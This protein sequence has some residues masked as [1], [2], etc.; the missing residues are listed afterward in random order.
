VK[1]SHIVELGPERWVAEQ[2]QARRGPS[3]AV[4]GLDDE[5]LGNVALR[6]PGRASPATTCRAIRA[7]DHPVGELSYWV[8]PHA[9]RRGVATA[10][11]IAMLDMA[12]GIEEVRSVVLDIEIDNVASIRVAER[13]GATR[14]EPTRVEYDRRGVPRE[15]AVFIV[16]V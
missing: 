12:R 9:R 14:R 7:A 4:C 3:M 16:K 8:L 10:A 11:A 15:L 1:W 5:V 2:R 6:L 13:V